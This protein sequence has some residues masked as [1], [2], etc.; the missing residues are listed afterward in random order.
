[1]PPLD[2]AKDRSG[3]ESSNEYK[4]LDTTELR[5]APKGTNVPGMW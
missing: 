2:S 5:P 3:F 4:L 1:M